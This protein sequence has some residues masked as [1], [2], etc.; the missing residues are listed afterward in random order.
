MKPQFGT[1]R[2][3]RKVVHERLFSLRKVKKSAEQCKEEKELSDAKQFSY[4]PK[5]VSK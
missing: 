2:A 5:L 3:N 1:T 4:K